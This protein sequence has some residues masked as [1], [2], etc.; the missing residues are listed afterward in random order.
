MRESIHPCFNILVCLLD[1]DDIIKSV[2]TLTQVLYK[3]LDQYVHSFR[4]D[5]QC[6][7]HSAKDC[8]RFF[9]SAST[10]VDLDL[11]Q[12]RPTLRGA[13]A[14]ARALHANLSFPGQYLSVYKTH[15]VSLKRNHLQN[16]EQIGG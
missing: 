5:S 3:R 7:Q 12:A 15:F 10:I 16:V 2:V 4:T 11:W 8:Q 14:Q 1:D 13:R 9:Q 6:G